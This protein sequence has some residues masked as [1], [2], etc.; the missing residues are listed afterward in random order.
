MHMYMW[1][2][3]ICSCTWICIFRCRCRCTYLFICSS[4]ICVGAGIFGYVA[5]DVYVVA[6]IGFYMHVQVRLYVGVVVDGYVNLHSGCRCTCICTCHL[7][8]C[9]CRRC[10]IRPSRPGAPYACLCAKGMYIKL[11]VYLHI[12]YCCALQV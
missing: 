3:S 6:Y 1:C 12:V 8:S 2:S 4:G 11:R 5:L 10:R 9:I 7:R